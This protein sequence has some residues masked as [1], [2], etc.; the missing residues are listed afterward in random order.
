MF[1]DHGDVQSDDALPEGD[2]VERHGRPRAGGEVG[3]KGREAVG[4]VV[5]GGGVGVVGVRDH[6][7]TLFGTGVHVGDDIV[8]RDAGSH[9][10][11]GGG[12][13]VVK[14]ALGQGDHDVAWGR[15]IQEG[16]G[17]VT[18]GVS[19]V[20]TGTGGRQVLTEVK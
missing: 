7:P 9:D 13:S 1:A 12:S 10:R 14:G 8:E 16:V 4:E 5:V 15:G 2:S 3:E 19:R 11:G 6:G 20:T 17:E 18:D